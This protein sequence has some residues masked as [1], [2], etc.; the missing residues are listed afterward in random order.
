MEPEPTNSLYLAK[1][2]E[3]KWPML[4]LQAPWRPGPLTPS[5]SNQGM[6]FAVC[7]RIGK[8]LLALGWGEQL[9]CNCACAGLATPLV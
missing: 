9:E 5:L 4:V 8:F 6:P 2:L 3:E 1:L 7:N